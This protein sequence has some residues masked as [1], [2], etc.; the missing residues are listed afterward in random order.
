MIIGTRKEVTK[1]MLQDSIVNIEEYIEEEISRELSHEI[2]K[3]YP[4]HKEDTQR[5]TM[6]YEQRVWVIT[7]EDYKK[8][9]NDIINIIE[10]NRLPANEIKRIIEI[11]T[12]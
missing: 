3:H 4:L 11:L 2:M 10:L 1:E 12:K 6:M 8:R 9:V 5:E 7:Q